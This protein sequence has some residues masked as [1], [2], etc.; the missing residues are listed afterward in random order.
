V[1]ERIQQHFEAAIEAHQNAL[2]HMVESIESAAIKL[3]NSLLADG[4]ILCCGNGG[5]AAQS[6]HF[7][8][9]L[10]NRFERERPGLPAF[11]LTADTPTITSI[12]NDYRYDE[13]FAKPVRAFGHPDDV[14]VAFTT[15]GH[16][17]SILEAVVA[18]HDRDMSVVAVTGRGGGALASLLRERDVELRVPAENTARIQEI[19]LLITHC[20]CDLIDRQLFG[21]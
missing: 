1:Q 9:E 20:L 3:A 2:A 8:S 17:P 5:S 6:Q 10:L 18:A 15:S 19:H 13:V 11:S 7:A 12:A 4:K 16:S 21:E 14:L